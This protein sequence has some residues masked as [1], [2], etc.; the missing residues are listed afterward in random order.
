MEFIDH[1]KTQYPNY[2]SEFEN[3]GQLYDQ[4]YDCF[5]IFGTFDKIICRLWHQLYVALVAF[6]KNPQ[7][8][9]G[10]DAAQV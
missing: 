1:C 5:V 10:H 6:L 3:L 9:S 2:S 4:K 8:F 7:V